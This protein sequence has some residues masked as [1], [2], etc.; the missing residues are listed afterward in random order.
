MRIQIIA[1]GAAALAL[2]LSLPAFAQDVPAPADKQVDFKADIKP[3]L[4]MHCVEC[5]REGKVKSELRLDV[6]EEALK[7][8]IEG[9]WFDTADSAHSL[10]IELTLGINPDFDRMPPKGDPLT[11]DQVALLRAV[12]DRTKMG[13]SPRPLP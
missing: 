3:I 9:P 5:H 10:L 12:A 11:S 8:G 13:R 1:R 6:K 7:G 4:E 2:G